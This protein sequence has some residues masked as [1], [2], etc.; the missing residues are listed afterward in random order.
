MGICLFIIKLQSSFL[1]EAQCSSRVPG[2]AGQRLLPA[3]SLLPALFTFHYW[4]ARRTVSCQSGTGP[5]SDE[6]II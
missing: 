3:F 2:W 5:V 4:P 6:A 1:A